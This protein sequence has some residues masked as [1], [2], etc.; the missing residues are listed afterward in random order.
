MVDLKTIIDHLPI[1]IF[2]VDRE[3]RILLANRLAEEMRFSDRGLGKRQRIGEMLGCANA[4]DSHAGCG[5]SGF[6]HLCQAKAMIDRAFA[7]QR[8]TGQFD[9][10]IKVRSQGVR[11]LR[12]TVNPICM[13]I[14]P[15]AQVQICTVTV[16]DMTDLKRKERLAAAT[17]TIGAICHEMNQ[18]LQAIMGNVE[19]LAQ[20]RLEDNAYLKI[21]RIFREIERIKMITKQLMN[22][23]DYRSKPY[24]ST[25]IL[26]LE[27]SGSQAAH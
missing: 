22:V 17:E 27:R 6:C 26:D 4:D 16:V 25:R 9:T 14:V 15:T 21:K 8:C 12:I 3:R 19:L 13:E 20:Y 10:E 7:T 2:V 23:T 5:S 24:L 18:P 1:A 11:S